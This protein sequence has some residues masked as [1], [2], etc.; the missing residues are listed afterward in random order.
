MGE[1]KNIIIVAGEASG[2]MHGANLV[3]EMLK[4]KP[5]LKFYGIGGVK[6]KETGVEILGDAS[7]MAVVGFSEVFSKFAF[8]LKTMDKM[9]KALDS[10]RPALL[11]LIDYPGFN[12][13]L[14]KAAKKKGIKVFYYI[15]PQV[16]AWRKGRINQIKKIVDRMAVVLPFEVDTY[17]SRGF[18]VDYVGHPLV[19]MVKISVSKEE[20]RK[21]LGL[22]GN[23]TTIGLLPGSRLKEIS[24][25]LPEMMRAA[26]ILQRNIK[27]I[28]FVLPKA[29]T[30]DEKVVTE[31]ISGF[32]V[33]VK[34]VTGHTYEA[35]S[36][37]DFAIVTSGTAT[38]ETGLL[39][40][41]MIIIYK[42][43]LLSYLIGRLV[44]RVNNIGLVNIIAGKTIVP[45]FI[46]KDAN[47][48][49]IAAETLAI[50]NSERYAEI[51]K[52]LTAISAKLGSPGAAARAAK[53]ACE[54]I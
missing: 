47:G 38:L 11:I 19:D 43:S 32:D 54:M 49:R 50:L 20:A 39:G 35:V 31:I 52:E 53:I 6:L 5:A 46:Q 27:D 16:W 40:V 41:P 10:Y 42:V 13:A 3:K 8:L 23:K 44:V 37:C 12:L 34:I 21:N 22:S 18:L 9:K 45:E 4:L 2:D 24:S 48:K 15:S 30:L 26:E 28:Q 25:L 51:K 29:D 14:A 7:R 36:C 1:E 17:A 33:K